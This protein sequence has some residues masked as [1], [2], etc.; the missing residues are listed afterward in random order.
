MRRPRKA[1]VNGVEITIEEAK[2]ILKK[3]SEK[4]SYW[5]RTGGV[6]PQIMYVRF[7]T[8]CYGDDFEIA[9]ISDFDFI[10]SN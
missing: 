3:N 4:Y 2:E 9:T 5:H 10:F 8:N 1:F 6:A 7:L